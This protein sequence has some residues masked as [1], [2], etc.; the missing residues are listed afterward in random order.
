MLRLLGWF[1]IFLL[2]TSLIIT[3]YYPQ[4]WEIL[5]LN[6]VFYSKLVI[7][8]SKTEII[9]FLSKMTVLKIVMLTLKRFIMD[10][11]VSRAISQH[12][13]VHVAP[14]AK[15]WW[16]SLDMKGMLLWFIPASI[17]TAASTWFVGLANTT[18]FLF[19]KT[20]IIGFF[21]LLWLIL[22]KILLFFTNS[23]FAQ[24]LELLAISYLIDK[25]TN[26]QIFQKWIKPLA[27]KM[28]H[29]FHV[30]SELI[31][32][33]IHRPIN[34]QVDKLGIKTAEKIREI[35]KRKD[36]TPVK[37]NDKETEEEG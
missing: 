16:Q 22:A 34:D 20:L 9:L 32:S 10:N 12:F 2:P 1:M 6:M 11:V 24:L 31:E 17:V 4:Y 30:F 33:K 29:L 27:G 18:L 3:L 15:K 21:K 28:G 23:F 19:I 35:R 37:N 26:T 7:K 5:L 13:T 25:I 8:A 14:E 36:R